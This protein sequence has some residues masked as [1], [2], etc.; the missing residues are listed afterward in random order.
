MG[1]GTETLT[2][3]QDVMRMEGTGGGGGN[4]W[5]SETLGKWQ[6]LSL[7]PGKHY[8]QKAHCVPIGLSVSDAPLLPAP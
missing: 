4:R 5:S 1:Y 2:Q 3:S 6:L 7:G 8:M